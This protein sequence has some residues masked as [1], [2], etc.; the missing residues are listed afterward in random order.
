[1]TPNEEKV[2]FYGSDKV[3]SVT[4][5]TELVRQGGKKFMNITL[6]KGVV[7][8]VP[9]EYIETLLTPEIKDLTWLTDQRSNFIVKSFIEL[10]LDL[11]VKMTELQ[12][13]IPKLKNSLDLSRDNADCALW[14]KD[15]YDISLVDID[16]VLKSKRITLDDVMHGKNVENS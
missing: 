13:F 9:E 8:V 15:S 12:Y 14:E 2:L 3:V 7:E 1:M 16:R 5:N 11:N 10:L 4:E 6:A